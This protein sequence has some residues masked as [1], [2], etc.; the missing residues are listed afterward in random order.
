MLGG[1]PRGGR[2]AR[3]SRRSERTTPSPFWVAEPTRS[4]D[5]RD[6]TPGEGFQDSGRL[7]ASHREA[8]AVDPDA[9]ARRPRHARHPRLERSAAARG[10]GADVRDPLRENLAR[11]VDRG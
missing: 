3:W 8:K 7:G 2:R 1:P 4:T 6:Y 10:H 5:D 11:P 9:V